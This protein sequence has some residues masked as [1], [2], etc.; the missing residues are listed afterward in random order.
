LVG[1]S[2]EALVSCHS[3]KGTGRTIRYAPEVVWRSP[4]DEPRTSRAAQASD[5]PVQPAATTASEPAAPASADKPNEHLRTL[6]LLPP[7]RFREALELVCADGHLTA[8]LA[9]RVKRLLATDTSSAALELTRRRCESH[10]NVE[11]HELDPVYDPLP[12]DRFDLIVYRDLPDYTGARAALEV[13][14]EKL[15]TALEPGGY[16]VCVHT[17]KRAVGT[18]AGNEDALAGAE[19]ARAVFRDAQGLQLLHEVRTSSGRIQLYQRSSVWLRWLGRSVPP[20]RWTA[21]SAG[22]LAP[23]GS[24]PKPSRGTVGAMHLPEIT[25]RLP[26]LMYH[27]IAT[28]GP[29]ALARYRTSPGDFEAQLRYL[30]DHGFTSA[31][32]DEWRAM[33]EVKQPLPGKRVLL[34]F[35]D[36]CTDFIETAWPL[37]E[38]YGFRAT[39]FL[40]TDAIGDACRWD[41]HL[42]DPA[43]VMSWNDLRALQKAGVEF[44]SHTATHPLLTGLSPDEMARE[45]LRSRATIA[46][47]LGLSV[48]SIA[49]PFGAVDRVVESTF[50]AAGYLY[51]VTCEH[52][53]CEVSDRLL[54]LPR[55]EVSAGL[56]VKEFGELLAL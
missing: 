13:V 35:D 30:R 55:I 2:G 6:E 36:G 56:G 42:G 7:R 9:S 40:P 34:T 8:Q 37:L 31:S 3:L 52:R 44:G 54:A 48:T 1:A 39:M 10:S 22:T 43:R 26:I 50:G 14:A 18:P 19:L 12:R 28:D 49:Y 27:R 45:A 5:A 38:R 46:E 15:A 16:F 47:E 17:P 21:D 33:R 51:G 29:A 32:L 53:C 23:T 11:V 24:T 4:G 25:S 41:A 20:I